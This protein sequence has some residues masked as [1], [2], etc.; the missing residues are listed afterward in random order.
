MQYHWHHL[1]GAGVLRELVLQPLGSL[2]N[3]ARNPR[4]LLLGI[5]GHLVGRDQPI[6]KNRTT[7]SQI[8]SE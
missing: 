7:P 8:L 5:Q 4:H 1:Y 3:P 6:K 2:G